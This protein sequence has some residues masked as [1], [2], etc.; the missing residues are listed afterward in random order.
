MNKIYF[1]C[2]FTKIFLLNLYKEIYF[3]I[4]DEFM[5]FYIQVYYKFLCNKVRIHITLNWKR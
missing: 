5:N 4:H 3:G 2:N 1:I